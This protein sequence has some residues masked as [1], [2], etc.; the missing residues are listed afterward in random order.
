MKKLKW[1]VLGCALFLGTMARAEKLSVEG[2]EITRRTAFRETFAEL[3]RRIRIFTSLRVE[4]L[5]R[6]ALETEARRIGRGVA[7]AAG[8]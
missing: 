7:E 3:E 2:S 4:A 8:G 5:D 1:L 6:L